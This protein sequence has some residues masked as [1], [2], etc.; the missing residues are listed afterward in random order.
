MAISEKEL[1]E[2]G[3]I[4]ATFSNRW[5]YAGPNCC[6]FTTL[7]GIGMDH[8]RARSGYAGHPHRRQPAPYPVCRH[9]FARCSDH[10]RVDLS[11]GSLLE[12][13]L[14]AEECPG[15]VTAKVIAC[16]NLSGYRSGL[17]GY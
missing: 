15:Q 12:S 5:H 3:F 7:P 13:I 11:T 10:C 4:G 1:L 2:A 16:N 9:E 14:P 17:T 6:T 8:G